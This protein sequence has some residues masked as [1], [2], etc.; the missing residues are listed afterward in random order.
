MDKHKKYVIKENLAALEIEGFIFK[1]IRGKGTE[2]RHNTNPNKIL[3]YIVL[4]Q[5][6]DNLH[7]Q[8]K[9]INDV[10]SL[11]FCKVEQLDE[12][13]SPVEVNEI[14]E[15]NLDWFAV[16]GNNKFTGIDNPLSEKIDGKLHYISE[17]DLDIFWDDIEEFG[18]YLDEID[19]NEIYAIYHRKGKDWY[20]A[21][22][23]DI[24]TLPVV[25]MGYSL[26]E[27]F[28]KEFVDEWNFYI[29]EHE[30]KDNKIY[31]ELKEALLINKLDLE[32]K[33]YI[34]GIINGDYTPEFPSSL[35]LRDSIPEIENYLDILFDII[36]EKLYP[37]RF[38][39]SYFD[40]DHLCNVGTNEFLMQ[41]KEYL[42]IVDY[43]N[44][45][46]KE[47]EKLGCKLT[48]SI[49]YKDSEIKQYAAKKGK[50]EYHFTLQEFLIYQSLHNIDEL[51]YEFSQFLYGK[52]QDLILETKTIKELKKK[53]N[54]V[55]VSFEDSINAGNCDSGTKQW[56]Y[57]KGIDFNNIGGIR[58]DYLLQLDPSSPRVI[59]AVHQA[60][61][62]KLKEA[63]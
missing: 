41:Y 16:H 17:F 31:N 39:Y 53:A 29:V 10:L 57:D 63:L 37:I 32:I 38:S 54:K 21:Q 45:L 26:N 6:E 7:G 52:L 43:L 44:K 8:V 47:L 60:I 23:Y 2:V 1:G 35:S 46:E 30:D 5:Y 33:G 19:P 55:F 48:Y 59:K 11:Y 62:T 36:Y 51:I 9:M 3:G 4:N 50:Y 61:R 25:N 49:V 22:A 24:M 15:R 20:I 27:P 42:G 56:L 34:N 14:I 58:G 40:L 13:Y 12:N 18:H 28:V